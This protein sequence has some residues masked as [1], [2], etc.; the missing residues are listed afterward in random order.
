M[1]HFNS[2]VSKF[3]YY[4]LC[5]FLCL[6]LFVPENKVSAKTTGNF[7]GYYVVQEVLDDVEMVDT[8]TATSSGSTINAYLYRWYSHYEYTH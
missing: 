2:S 3:I 4:I 6:C 5:T 1:D 8:Y 7:Y